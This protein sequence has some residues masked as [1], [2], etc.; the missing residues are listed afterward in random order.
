MTR[1]HDPQNML[2]LTHLKNQ[3]PLSQ[4]EAAQ[5]YQ[6]WRLSA[7]IKELRYQ[8]W[9]IVTEIVQGGGKRWARYWLISSIPRS[10]KSGTAP[11]DEEEPS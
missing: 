4:K 8:G 6:C 11:G 5:L 2:I 10:P 9:N 7:R 1:A 3:G